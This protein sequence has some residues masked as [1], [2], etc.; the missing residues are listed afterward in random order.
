MAGLDWL[1]QTL[2]KREALRTS[3]MQSNR[4]K[5]ACAP[6]NIAPQNS[7]S[8]FPWRERPLHSLQSASELAGVSVASLYRFEREGRLAF[9]RL[10][11]R[12]LVETDGLVSLIESAEKWSPSDRAAIAVLSR[13]A[14]A[15]AAWQS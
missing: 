4:S 8:G 11:G 14:S 10:G 5:R 7:K 2:R 12:T 9:R 6:N 3:Q 13:S 1:R 15:R